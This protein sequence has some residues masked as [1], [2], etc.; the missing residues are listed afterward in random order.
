MIARRRSLAAV[1][2]IGALLLAGCSSTSSQAQIDNLVADITNAANARD[3]G[4]MTRKADDL[5]TLVNSF[6]GSE[7]PI[8]EV[9]RILVLAQAVK[10][11]ATLL[12][13]QPA[14]TE[15]PSET[16]SATPTPEETTPP[17]TETKPPPPTT[18]PPTTTPPTTPPTTTPP[19]TT[20]PP[21]KP[22]A[23]TSKPPATTSKPPAAASKPSAAT[24][25]SPAKKPTASVGPSGEAAPQKGSSAGV[26][27]PTPTSAP[28]RG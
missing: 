3:A 14:S 1:A 11:D 10:N 6:R 13:A 25:P 28:T 12:D 9:D 5:V 7:L 23:A 8:A 27:A 21:T 4:K 24:T 19:T 18:P 17:P 15:T 20:S 22:P 16:P 26:T 2:M